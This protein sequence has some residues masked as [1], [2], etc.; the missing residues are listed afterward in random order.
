MLTIHPGA[1]MTSQLD[2]TFHVGQCI[3]QTKSAVEDRANDSENVDSLTELIHQHKPV[4]R[5]RKSLAAAP[6]RLPLQHIESSFNDTMFELAGSNTGKENVPPSAETRKKH[7]AEKPKSA[8]APRMSYQSGVSQKQT[9]AS[10]N[11]QSVIARK[12]VPLPRSLVPQKRPIAA[13]VLTANTAAAHSGQA[14]PPAKYSVK[15]SQA[16]AL[17]PPKSNT[18]DRAEKQRQ[19]REVIAVKRQELQ[20]AKLADYPLLSEDFAQPELYDDGWLSHQEVAV[21]ETINEIFRSAVKTSTSAQADQ[22]T[23]LRD[24]M[25]EIYHSPDTSMLYRRMIASLSHGALKQPKELAASSSLGRD[26]GRRRRFLSL[27]LDN[28]EENHLRTA[29]EVVVGRQIPRQSGGSANALTAGEA[30]LDPLINRRAITRFLETFFVSAAD[31]EPVKTLQNDDEQTLQSARL[32]KTTVRSLMLI[33]LLDRAKLEND[34]EGCLFQLSA[35]KKSSIEMLQALSTFL[36]PSTGDIV[37]VLRHMDYEIAHVQDPLDEV[38]YHVE[39]LAVDLRDG[40]ILTHLVETLLY[41]QANET[42]DSTDETSTL[43]ITL[44]DHTVLKSIIQV[45]NRPGVPTRLLS[46]HVKLPCTGRAQKLYN[47]QIALSALECYDTRGNNAVAD[48]TAC[49]IVDGH[50]EKTIA[51]L[52]SLVGG[53]GLSKLVNW[54]DLAADTTRI[55]GCK[56]LTVSAATREEQAELL[57]S[58]ASAYCASE[59][60]HLRITNLTSSFADGRAYGA[61]IRGYAPFIS[62]KS[63]KKRSSKSSDNP[64]SVLA[65]QLLALGCSATF[66]SQVTSNLTVVPNSETT[67]ANLALLASR[68][69]PLSRRYRAAVAIQRAYREHRA[70]MMA[71]IKMQLKDV[72]SACATVVQ[73][74]N[75]IVGAAETI[76]RAWRKTL[77]GRI[78]KLNSEVEAFQCLAKGWALRKNMLLANART[79]ANVYGAETRIMGGW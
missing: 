13:R 78:E 58:W 34:V 62:L 73:T 59:G 45:Q 51:L 2:D 8:L 42:M 63:T 9:A 74:R 72:A 70:A 43:A 46:Q 39:N 47:V 52:W 15:P 19:L 16:K 6:R 61:I 48:V 14:H 28:Y 36:L 18:V 53:F 31:V 40:V 50:R 11:R 60:G 33:W 26:L 57:K 21:T 12:S 30:I 71:T 75:R 22:Q 5:P 25:I 32:R 35:S 3:T 41:Q 79:Q 49:D 20:T 24:R 7:T 10:H 67:L 54:R 55:Q 44:P 27:L 1:K 76:Q 37:R 65:E 68:L 69:L 17:M 23:S 38:V 4:R 66:A 29:A 77:A 64:Q 56:S